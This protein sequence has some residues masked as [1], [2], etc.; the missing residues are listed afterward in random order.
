MN[1]K[2]I[3]KEIEKQKAELTRI[4]IS[5][6]KEPERSNNISRISKT[7]LSLIKILE[8]ESFDKRA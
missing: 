3:E 7:I 8:K 5:E 4:L 6:M 1:K 2:I